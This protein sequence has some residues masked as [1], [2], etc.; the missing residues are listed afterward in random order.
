MDQDPECILQIPLCISFIIYSTWSWVR[1]FNKG[2]VKP[3]L[4]RSPLSM[5]QYLK[6]LLS[7][8]GA[9]NFPKVSLFQEILNLGH[10]FLINRSY[11]RYFLVQAW[12]WDCFL[13]NCFVLTFL[14][15]T[16]VLIVSLL[17]IVFSY[18]VLKLK[19]D[20]CIFK[21]SSHMVV[22]CHLRILSMIIFIQL[23]SYK[24]WVTPIL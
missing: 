20:E 8:L 4:Y 23:T 1:H 22:S 2:V 15:Y 16:R 3:L 18:N 5:A 24:F 12:V 19:I 10:P 14:L 7:F 21:S 9:T 6:F 11:T 17:F 13:G